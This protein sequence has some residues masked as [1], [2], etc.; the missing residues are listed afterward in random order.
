MAERVNTD[1]YTPDAGETVG[2]IICGFCGTVMNE[3]LYQFG[4]TG[5]VE[6]MAKHK[7][8]YDEFS[9]PYREISWHIKVKELI[10]TG[11]QFL[12]REMREM[13]LSE[14]NDILRA[15]GKPPYVRDGEQEKKWE[16][17]KT[18]PS[19]WYTPEPKRIYRLQNRY[20][21]S[22]WEDM[23][24][25]QYTNPTLAVFEAYERCLDSIAFGMVRVVEGDRVLVE[26]PAGGYK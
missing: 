8:A 4:A 17:P 20:Q 22:G 5:M 1:H 9:C 19:M 18:P 11:N 10:T 21:D 24:G 12:C 26:F 13:C 14:A 15:Y 7:H 6:A 16:P 2:A 25:T 3:R 23:G